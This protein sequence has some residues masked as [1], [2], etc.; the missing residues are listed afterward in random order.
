MD[1]AITLECGTAEKAL[2]MVKMYTVEVRTTDYFYLN[3]SAVA[4]SGNFL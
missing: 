3:S 4:V 2:L 1:A